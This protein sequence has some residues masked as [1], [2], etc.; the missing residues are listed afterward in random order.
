VCVCVFMR[1]QLLEPS[2]TYHSVSDMTLAEQ[3]DWSFHCY[4]RLGCANDL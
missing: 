1:I 2:L 4:V 3:P